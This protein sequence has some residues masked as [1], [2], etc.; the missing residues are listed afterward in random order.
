[1]VADVM[2]HPNAPLF[3]NADGSPG[4]PAAAI[5]V[6]WSFDLTAN[7]FRREILWDIAGEFPRIDDRR[8]GPSYRHSYFARDSRNAPGVQPDLIAHFDLADGRKDVFDLAEGDVTSEPVFVARSEAA[9]R[10][11]TAGCWRWPIA[12]RKIAAT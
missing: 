8:A 5:L 11:G 4:K 1:M 6:R 2:E 9:V 7:S 3:P 10:K 12:V